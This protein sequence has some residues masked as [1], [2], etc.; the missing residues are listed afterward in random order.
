[1]ES[2]HFYHELESDAVFFFFFVEGVIPF[3]A[4]CE[5]QK[6]KPQHPHR[7][8][9]MDE[10]SQSSGESSVLS[11]PG[12]AHTPVLQSAL[13]PA[14]SSN[15]MLVPRRLSGGS[16]V[17]ETAAANAGIVTLALSIPTASGTSNTVVVT[18]PAQ[19]LQPHQPQAVQRPPSSNASIQV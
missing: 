14:P 12:P 18:S 13:S 11:P 16:D 19:V 10:D 9:T 8:I 5:G 4:T 17:I 1:M 15:A 6:T 2:L 7:Y 3:K